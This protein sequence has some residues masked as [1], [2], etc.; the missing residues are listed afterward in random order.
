MGYIDKTVQEI[1][2]YERCYYVYNKYIVPFVIEEK[3]VRPY[4]DRVYF[5]DSLN[6]AIS[7]LMTMNKDKMVFRADKEKGDLEKIIRF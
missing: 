3:R 7:C 2:V 5:F 4:V 1:V 6:E